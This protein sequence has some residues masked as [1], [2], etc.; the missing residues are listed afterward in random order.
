MEKHYA[1]VDNFATI[2]SAVLILFGIYLTS[3]YS[4]LL[5]HSIAEIFSIVVAFGIFMI[6]WNSRRVLDNNYLL[7]IGVAYLF[8][9]GLDMIHA[10][11]Y[12]GMGVFRGDT[13]NL[14][15]ELWIAARY[16]ES[17][18][19]LI[20]PL[21]MGRKL[22]LNLFLFGYALAY[23]FLLVSIFY[24]NIFPDCFV[25]GVGLTP[26]KK[27]SEYVISVILFCAIFILYQKRQEF[28]TMVFRLLVASILIT[29]ASEM[30]FTFYTS[31]YGL[32][33]LIGH[34]LKIISYYFIYKA[35][36]QT[37]LTKPY[38]LFFRNLKQS[39]DKL[40]KAHEEM[41][42]RVQERTDKLSKAN[43]ELEREIE[44]RQRAENALRESE[45]KYR[46]LI[47]NQ[48][49]LAVKIDTG[50]KFLFV[51][52]SYCA[53][54]GKAEEELIGKESMTLVHEDDRE[55][56]ARAM[57]DIHRPPY[58]CYIRHRAST[59]D[60]WRWLAWNYKAVLDEENKVIAI[61]GAGRD[62][63]ERKREEEAL[64]KSQSQQKAI[65]DNIPDMAWLK[66]RESR[67]I[68][69][70]EPFGKACG[71]KPED[72]VGKTDL[73]IWPK[74]LAERYRAD[75]KEVM[76]SGKQKQVEEPLVDKEGNRIWIETIKTPIYNEKGEVIGTTGIARDITERKQAEEEHI[77]LITAIE[78][79]GEGVSITDKDEI[80]QY[81]NPAFERITGYNRE[82]V[83]GQSSRMLMGTEN[84][85]LYLNIKNG[86]NRG[87]LWSGC[88]SMIRKDGAACEIEATVSP[89]RDLSANIINH[90]AVMRDVTHEVSI[91]KRLHQAQKME[92]IGTLAGGIAHDFNNILSAIMG[93]I[94]L[95]LNDV[96]KGSQLYS[97]LQEVFKAGSRAKELVSQILTFS[98]LHEEDRR[99]IPI[100]PIIKETLKLLRA[101][102]PAT[103]EIRQNIEP[104]AGNILADPTQ[105][106]QVLMN[107]C[108][109]AAHA[110]YEKGGILEV[111]LRDVEL[112][113][114]FA[115]RYPD[116]VPGPYQRLSVIDTGHGMTSE[117][118]EHIFE[119]Y[120]TTKDKGKG[121]GLGLSVVHGIV[122]NLG[123]IITAYSEPGKGSTFTVY[124]PVIQSTQ[125]QATDN[126]EPL[127]TGDECILFVDDEESLATMAERMLGFLGYEVIART[128][129]IEALEI[130]RVRPGQFDLVITDM[131]MPHMTG[132]A[133][134]GEIM[135]IRPDIPII[136]CTGF[137]ERITEEKA[138][139]LGIQ[140]FVMKPFF[141]REIAGLIRRVLDQQKQKDTGCLP[142]DLVEARMLRSGGSHE[143]KGQSY[144]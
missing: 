143:N 123:G 46:L 14:S 48:K 135:R 125:F 115:A 103:I 45:E 55:G 91:E 77:R 30:T 7:I 94:E 61:V 130:F 108:T 136:I 1:I 11:A 113:S 85:A 56:T 141:M 20:S 73:D 53:L 65:L 139:A 29:I 16:L 50:G 89:I 52:P 3:S 13:A 106:H 84:E 110:M 34:Y 132:E 19:L 80:I 63:S 96:S 120:F 66:D 51:S 140:A 74:E 58:T 133:L 6:A 75:D 88:I 99:L 126:P 35:I 111:S 98:R 32:S 116:I 100:S 41:E 72:L 15:V 144:P 43:E 104:D 60:G 71:V 12:K 31:V 40:K 76:E 128:S 5:F 69:V 22:K 2:I 59:N 90:V 127:P 24:W 42:I 134:A 36:I 26:F 28:D 21:L 102:L 117:I 137:S 93:Y 70:N 81:V 54:F 86:L 47:E 131:T 37:A 95:A 118:L 9:G 25:E 64:Q 124:F 92:A 101:S 39:R 122:K 79:A 119:P 23:T 49:D 57:E 114:H 109:N 121:T 129:S 38:N 83:V 27:A 78:Q 67:F 138:G 87:H 4:Y 44:E 8:I 17:I 82:E 33:N 107:L 112:D 62:I 18:S 97:D 10:L 142:L 68:S 105:I